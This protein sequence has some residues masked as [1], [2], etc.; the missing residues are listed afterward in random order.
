MKTKHDEHLQWDTEQVNAIVA[1]LA[2]LRLLVDLELVPRYPYF[3]TKT[4]P[5]GRCKEIRDE[6]FM[7][8][9]QRL[10]Q[11]TEPGLV[12]I[13]DRLAQGESLIKIWGSLRGVYFQNAMAIGDWYLDV[14][15]DTVNPN[16]PRIEVLPLANS[17]FAEISSF[18]HFV[19]VAQLYWKVD[20]YRNDICPALA[21]YM[22]LL[23]I[24]KN[25]SCWLG[26]A[27]D[28]MLAVA[29]TSQFSASERILST[30]PAPPQ[31]A[32]TGWK[33]ALAAL[34]QH[35][36]LH[37]QGDA[38]EYCKAYRSKHYEQDSTI[39]DSAVMAF[40]TLPKSISLA[41]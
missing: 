16:K 24:A 33:K 4:Y 32:I 30:L 34:Q 26:E 8:L 38:M 23:Y 3:G 17:G 31:A 21:P 40:L 20:V 13:R 5:L 9:Q 12:L 36:F 29:T 41:G 25:G 35:E 11:A 10:P 2:S 6:V 39:R 37:Q 19:S 27:S 14:S 18:E 28:N 7:L 1:D 15:N 22:P